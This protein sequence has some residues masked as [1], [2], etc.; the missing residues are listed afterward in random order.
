MK[1][2]KTCKALSAWVEL[3]LFQISLSALFSSYVPTAKQKNQDMCF[4]YYEDSLAD[5]ISLPSML[6][7]SLCLLFRICHN[8]AGS[9]NPVN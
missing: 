2:I 5:S 6:N 9:K 7:L 8:Q 4:V 1:H 3:L